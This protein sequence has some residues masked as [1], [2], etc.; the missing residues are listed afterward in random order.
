MHRSV[1]LKE[2]IEALAV[3][4][5]GRYIDATHGEGGH[6]ALIR[7]SGGQVLGIDADVSQV[8]KHEDLDYT[9]VVG[10][11]ANIQTI[12]KE[13]DF[14]PVDGVL[15][16]FGLSMEQL[17]KSRRGFS[18]QR[19]DEPLDM[20]IGENDVTA[21]EILEDTASEEL[22]SL[23]SKYSEELNAQAIA[24]EIVKT[25]KEGAFATVGDLIS[26][27]NRVLD[28]KNI[29]GQMFRSQVYARIFQALRIIV[30]DEFETIEKGL[31]GALQIL[32][33]AGR[34]V[35]ITF[36]SLEDRIVKLFAREHATDLEDDRI[37]V[38]KSRKL[39][40]FE[41]S[42]RLRLFIKK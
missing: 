41:R 26:V 23:L 13:N 10:N 9:V 20:R 38:E 31:E 2:A 19:L 7:A 33:P 5:N 6:S 28:N 35:V 17:S 8:Q 18:Y 40:T 12:A 4:P 34:I 3:R 36:H 30:N 16:D 11:F 29:H 25:R 14:I 27:I 22:V 1:F 15:F 37:K 21:Q 42:A 32:K 24:Y 39:Q